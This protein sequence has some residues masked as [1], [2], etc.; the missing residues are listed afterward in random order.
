MFRYIPKSDFLALASPDSDHTETGFDAANAIALEVSTLWRSDSRAS[1]YV[2]FALTDSGAIPNVF[3]AINTRAFRNQRMDVMRGSTIDGMKVDG[4]PWNRIQ[5]VEV[6]GRTNATWRLRFQLDGGDPRV[7]QCGYVIAANAW[8]T[9]NTLATR[10]TS[11]KVPQLQN[12]AETGTPLLSRPAG[13]KRKVT[14]KFSG[15]IT[16]PDFLKIYEMIDLLEDRQEP[17]L[18]QPSDDRPFFFFGRLD[19]WNSSGV[20]TSESITATFVTDGL[21]QQVVT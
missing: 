12:D 18:I 21:G 13:K 2:E 3:A 14:L 9:S 10:S 17:A 6:T 15:D 4:F 8:R 19:S 16:N 1:A 20:K 7:W 11:G 5:V